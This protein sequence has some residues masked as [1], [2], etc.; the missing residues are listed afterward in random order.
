MV[1]L[2]GTELVVTDSGDFTP[3]GG[4]QTDD[5]PSTGIFLTIGEP[6][7]PANNKG[8]F[9]VTLKDKN[10]DERAKVAKAWNNLAAVRI[11]VFESSNTNLESTVDG[12]TGYITG[13]MNSADFNGD[14]GVLEVEASGV[15]DINMTEP[16]TVEG[17]LTYTTDGNG[18]LKLELPIISS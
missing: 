12:Q 2:K 10:G 5:I 15:F 7:A 14:G 4:N 16:D 8:H 6:T 1:T 18:H 17:T 3:D 9:S 11:T 13:T